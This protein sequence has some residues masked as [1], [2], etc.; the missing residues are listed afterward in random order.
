MKALNNINVFVYVAQEGTI[1]KASKRLGLSPAS[2]SKRLKCFEEQ[3]GVRLL[4]RTARSVRLTDEGYELFEKLRVLLDQFEE[5]TA[6]VS[7]RSEKVSGT[8]HIATSST[9]GHR[10]ISPMVA[11]FSQRNP[12]LTVDLDVCSEPVDL[13]RDG[14]DVAILP[15]QPENSTLIARQLN[16]SEHLLCASPEYLRDHPPPRKP[17]DLHDHHCLLREC[18]GAFM[19]RWPL[20]GNGR[21]QIVQVHG[22]LIASSS[23][24]I[25]DW[26]LDGQGIALMSECEV[27]NELSDGRIVRVLEE[28]ELPSLEVYVI[29][30]ARRNLPAKTRS[31]VEYV[32]QRL[33]Q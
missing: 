19:D 14:Y 21:R 24:V 6:S 30:A 10:H 16:V 20:I 28:Y 33:G 31:F 9:L 18:D 25:K 7:C 29:Y 26:V 11:E 3:V 32:M 13:L 1:S 15:G 17:E 2:I 22:S 23:E 5:A 4:N 12:Q 8:L 27:Y